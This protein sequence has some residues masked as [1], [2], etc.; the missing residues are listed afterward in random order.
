MDFFQWQQ[1]IMSSSAMV[2]RMVHE[3]SGS[4]ARHMEAMNKDR[5]VA[6]K[7]VWRIVLLLEGVGARY[8]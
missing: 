6:R 4:L 2:F 3:R 7:A 8:P 1:L 5:S